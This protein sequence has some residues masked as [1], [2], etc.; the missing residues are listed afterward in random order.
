M[1]PEM[2]DEAINER[3]DGPDPQPESS[4]LEQS[5]T[6]TSPEPSPGAAFFDALV[7]GVLRGWA[8][9]SSLDGEGLRFSVRCGAR[10]LGEGTADVFREDLRAAGIGDGRHGFAIHLSADVRDLAGRT[11]E[12]YTEDGRCLDA[13]VFTI[14]EAGPPAWAHLRPGVGA[15]VRATISSPSLTGRECI[16]ELCCEGETISSMGAEFQRGVATADFEVPLRLI[17]GEERTYSLNIAG[18]PYAIAIERLLL[19]PIQTP[20]QRHGNAL[21]AAALAGT[22][23]HRYESLNAQLQHILDGTTPLTAEDLTRVHA[24]VAEGWLGR[25][26]FPKIRL[27]AFDEPSASIIVPAHD[28]IELTYHACASI[29]L[30]YNHTPYEVIVVDDA[31][32]DRTSEI[33]TFVDNV[34]VVRN[35]TNLGF[36]RSVNKA[37]KQARGRY[38][39]ILNND[40]EVTSGWLDE[41]LAPLDDPDIGLVGSKLLNLDGS[42][43]EAGGIVWGNGQPWNVG[44]D[45]NPWAPEYNYARDVD[46]VSGA[47]MA[48]PRSLWKDIGGFSLEFA[49][50]YYEDTDLA[51]KVREAGRRT[52]YAPLS[53]VVHFEGMSHGRDVTKGVKRYQIVNEAKFRDKWK[54]AYRDNGEVGVDLELQKDRGIKRRVLFID[55]GTP[56]PQQDAGSYAEIQEMSLFQSFGFKVSFVPWN[57]APTG[58]T[59]WDLQRRGIEVLH[60]PFY[61]SPRDVLERRGREFDAVYVTRYEVA[62]SFLACTRETT[63]AKFIFN[64]A[65][66]HFLRLLRAHNASGEPSLEDVMAV[67]D[68]ELAVMKNAD[69]IVSYSEIE[70]AVILSHNLEDENVFHCPWVIGER[71]EGP[72]FEEREGIAFLGGFLHRPNLEGIR[73]FVR[74]I[75]PALLE[76]DPDLILHIYGSNAPREVLDLA[77][78][79]VRVVGFVESLDEVFHS[80]RVF[81]APLLSGAGLKGKVVEAM[82]YGVPTVLSPIAAEATGLTNGINARIADSTPEWVEGILSYYHDPSA[83]TQARLSMREMVDA[84]YSFEAGRREWRQMLTY[85][86]LL[87]ET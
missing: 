82:A 80:H 73:Y 8:H 37:A 27:P 62:E 42:I 19:R 4:V 61:Q 24:V 12:L 18:D 76:R 15:T 78:D 75:L 58:K 47:S 45:A 85:L 48:L 52:V 21:G 5:E 28:K 46:Y 63:N 72:A 64:N 35:E 59:T 43:Q 36:L 9:D 41:L 3:A 69:A 79:N 16:L 51:F 67:R 77:G 30:A 29:A 1:I 49:P 74:E 53:K 20:W 32:T 25:T 83:W 71:P 86:D 56:D 84:K 31:S 2:P 54:E 50:A 38:L 60:Q 55:F 34:V 33:E 22:A 40:T 23:G 26:R 7:G 14:P 17:D 68:R 66:L 44:R 39:V 70:R 65:D 11:L 6:E 81:V 57:G 13:N 87:S 10:T